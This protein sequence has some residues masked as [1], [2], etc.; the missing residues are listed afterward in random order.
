MKDQNLK[1][2][3]CIVT[4]AAGDIGVA[5]SREFAARGGR[6]LM[7]DVD[8]NKATARAREFDSGESR[9]LPWQ[10]DV[11][12]RDQAF[13][14]VGEAVARFGQVDIL[15]NGAAT[16]TPG[17]T[18]AEL[19]PLVWQETLDVNLSGAVW[20]SQAALQRMIPAK[21]GVII[22]LASQL[23]QVGAANRAAYGATKAALI[24]LARAMAVD[25]AQQGIR[26][27]SLSAGAV[28]TSRLE[29]RYGSAQEAVDT[30]AH[31]YPIGRLGTPE[32]VAK[33]AAF[34]ASDDAAFMTGTDVLVDGGYTAY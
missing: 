11:S 5:I 2:R 19:D 23:G 12:D 30:L 18:I 27:V 16:H 21:K 7:V 3:A 33:A 29:R 9:C 4:G 15:V 8:K 17:T 20:M 28:L 13:A 25:H 10:C 26:V 1:D 24:Q 31:K 22:H 14:A 32:D 34:I 6:V